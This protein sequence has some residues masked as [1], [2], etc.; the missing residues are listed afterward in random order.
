MAE[1]TVINEVPVN[2]EETDEP[3]SQLPAS[4]SWLPF[5]QYYVETITEIAVDGITE[6]NWDRSGPYLSM[7]TANEAVEEVIKDRSQEMAVFNAEAPVYDECVDG[8]G[9]KTLWV[10]STGWT[11]E[12]CAVRSK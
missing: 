12:V 9:M 11:V 1:I 8:E 10:S 4:G 6:S 7:I 5:Y 3:S 2:L